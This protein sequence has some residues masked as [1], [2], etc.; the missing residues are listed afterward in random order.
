LVLSMFLSFYVF[1]L[2][3]I[4]RCD[5]RIYIL[6]I[7]KLLGL[8]DGDSTSSGGVYL[9][10]FAVV[11]LYNEKRRCLKLFVLLGLLDT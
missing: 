3:I 1:I 2:C 9:Y 5:D 10:F 6:N 7:D 4:V 11:Y 8:N